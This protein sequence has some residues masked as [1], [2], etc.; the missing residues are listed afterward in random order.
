M[1]LLSMMS[2]GPTA[3]KTKEAPSTVAADRMKTPMPG[4]ARSTARTK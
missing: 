3:M 1:Y 4:L 2:I